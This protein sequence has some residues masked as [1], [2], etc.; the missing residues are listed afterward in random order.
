MYSESVLSPK[1]GIL[2]LLKNIMIK[3]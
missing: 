1:M 3:D 2:L